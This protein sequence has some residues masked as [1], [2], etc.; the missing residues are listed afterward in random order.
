MAYNEFTNLSYI[1]HYTFLIYPKC[2]LTHSYLFDYVI[3]LIG[4]S[5]HLGFLYF[6]LQQFFIL[7]SDYL[8]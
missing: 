2:L 8:V 1:H 7:T 3:S 4:I 6:S 5:D